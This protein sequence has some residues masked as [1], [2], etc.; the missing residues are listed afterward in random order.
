MK[1][2]FVQCFEKKLFVKFIIKEALKETRSRNGYFLKASNIKLVLSVHSQ[3][4]FNF[5]GCLT[6][7]INMRFLLASL[8]KPEV[9]KMTT[10]YLRPIPLSSTQQ[11]DDLAFVYKK[12]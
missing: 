4:V 10:S 7:K 12:S 2:Q 3:M 5:L 11:V 9:D 8:K 1:V 6:E